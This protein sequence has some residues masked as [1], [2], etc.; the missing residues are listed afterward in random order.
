MKR[1]KK[2][3]NSVQ[4]QDQLTL[5]LLGNCLN[6][7]E[8]LSLL[9]K[10]SRTEDFFIGNLKEIKKWNSVNKTNRISKQRLHFQILKNRSL[11]FPYLLRVSLKYFVND[12]IWKIFLILTL[13]R[14]LKLKLFDKFGKSKAFQ[15][16][17]IS[18]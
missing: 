6:S 2:F 16:A 1:N 10:L 18:N 5:L 17:L 9:W 11:I 14:P 8:I 15:S 4:L 3:R 7:L 13:P 12:C